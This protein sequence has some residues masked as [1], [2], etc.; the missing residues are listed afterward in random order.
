MSRSVWF[1]SRGR[2]P[3]SDRDLRTWQPDDGRTVG[4]LLACDVA[5]NGPALRAVRL[6]GVVESSIIDQGAWRYFIRWRASCAARTGIT[7]RPSTAGAVSARPGNVV[8]L[9]GECC[10]CQLHSQ[11]SKE[12]GQTQLPHRAGFHPVTA[13][14]EPYASGSRIATPPCAGHTSAMARWPP[15]ATGA[16]SSGP[17]HVGHVWAMVTPSLNSG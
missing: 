8:P 5:Q 12:R 16:H 10:R 1:P 9:A 3:S 11:C 2:D 17:A 14:S 15:S 4:D 13:L 6:P 7:R